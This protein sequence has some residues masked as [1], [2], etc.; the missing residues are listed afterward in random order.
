MATDNIVSVIASL[1]NADSLEIFEMLMD[2]KVCGCKIGERFGLDN[3][4]VKAKMAPMVGAGLVDTIHGDEWD[5]YRINETRMCLLSKYFNDMIGRC[6]STGCKC[7]CGE[8]CC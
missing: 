2:G 3:E 6:R 5:K 1:G 4:G 8:G 7:K